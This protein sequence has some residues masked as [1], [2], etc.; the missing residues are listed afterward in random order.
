MNEPLLNH[1]NSHLPVVNG[2]QYFNSV[3]RFELTNSMGFSRTVL[4][5]YQITGRNGEIYKLYKT[6]E[7]NW[8]DIASANPL[9]AGPLLRLLKLEIDYL[10]TAG[11]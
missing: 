10:E 2:Q 7:R 11:S 8:Y 4:N 9:T 3:V 6:T 5:E 1:D